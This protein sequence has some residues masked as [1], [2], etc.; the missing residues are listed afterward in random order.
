MANCSFH[1]LK[2]EQADETVDMHGQLG[3]NLDT[4]HKTL[5]LF[6]LIFCPEM[7]AHYFIWVIRFGSNC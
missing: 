1:N 7:H 6:F 5:A 3:I 4:M 2:R